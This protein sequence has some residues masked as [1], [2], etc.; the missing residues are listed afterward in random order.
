M[1][2]VQENHDLRDNL[3]DLQDKSLRVIGLFCGW[4]WRCGHGD[5]LHV[6]FHRRTYDDGLHLTIHALYSPHMANR[7][8]GKWAV[9]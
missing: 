3:A 9:K 2:T 4:L 7:Q 5:V 6:E 1:S 8:V